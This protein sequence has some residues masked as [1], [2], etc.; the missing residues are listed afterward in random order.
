MD[1]RLCHFLK[2]GSKRLVG[3]AVIC[4]CGQS[5]AGGKQRWV[6]GAWI[7]RVGTCEEE[8]LECC[9]GFGEVKGGG[10]ERAFWAEMMS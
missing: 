1:E 7:I 6:I 2:A 3:G 9:V 4:V 8:A 10:Q 5:L